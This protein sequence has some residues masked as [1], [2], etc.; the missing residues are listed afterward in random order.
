MALESGARCCRLAGA[1]CWVSPD[2][3]LNIVITQGMSTAFAPVCLR[4][5]DCAV[6]RNILWVPPKPAPGRGPVLNR[7]AFQPLSALEANTCC[8][9]SSK[10]SPL[11]DSE[12]GSRSKKQ[13]GISRNLRF[14]L[15]H[16]AHPL[17]CLVG[18]R[19]QSI[20]LHEQ[21]GLMLF[22]PSP[23]LC[24]IQARC[25]SVPRARQHLL[26]G[27]PVRFRRR[28]L[29]RVVATRRRH[30]R[31]WPSRVRQPGQCPRKIP[32]RCSRR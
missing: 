2:G 12:P 5:A 32:K 6:R 8:A 31:M 14:L 30:C 15:I 11:L 10:K 27:C 25:P 19:G 26:D 21:N 18:C 7:T 16:G 13:L 9:K 28:S 3:L 20:F 17:S 23:E 24:C 4:R 22:M 29:Q 1:G